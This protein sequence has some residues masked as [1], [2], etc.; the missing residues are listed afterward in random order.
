MGEVSGKAIQIN[1]TDGKGIEQT[2]T[3]AGILDSRIDIDL[4]TARGTGYIQMNDL[5]S[6]KLNYQFSPSN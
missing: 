4:S 5:S 2:L 6:P 1:L 3:Q